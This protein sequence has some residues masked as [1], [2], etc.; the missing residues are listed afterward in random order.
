MPGTAGERGDGHAGPGVLIPEKKDQRANRLAR[1]SAGGRA[2]RFDKELY[3]RRNTVERAINKSKQFRAV[4]T[5]YDKRLY[6][7]EGTV[8]AAAVMIRLRSLRPADPPDTAQR[9]MITTVESLGVLIT[10]VVDTCRA[11]SKRRPPVWWSCP[12]THGPEVFVSHRNARLT[13]HGRRIL[14]E[15]VRSKKLRHMPGQLK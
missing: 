14:V 15:R 5:H 1:G 4:A 2:P 10:S 6:I 8:T 11:R 3:A 9:R 13:V 7:F 12:G